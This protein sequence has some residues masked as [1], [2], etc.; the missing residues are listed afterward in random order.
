[1][2]PDR[3][4]GRQGRWSTAGLGAVAVLVFLDAL[5]GRHD[6]LSG[7]FGLAPFLTAA[8]A[9]TSGTTVVALATV[10][11]S[12]L[13][14]AADGVAFDVALLRVAIVAVAGVAAAVAAARRRAADD[15]LDRSAGWRR[16]PNG[17]S[18]NRSPRGRKVPPGG[19]LRVGQR[20]GERRRRPL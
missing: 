1:M 9:D 15:R 17:P 3:G 10:A 18:S 2:R 6:N 11:A 8:G 19:D 12:A 20:G 14:A 16:W 13:A 5:L 4:R 7:T